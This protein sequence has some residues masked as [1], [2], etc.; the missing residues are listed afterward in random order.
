MKTFSLFCFVFILTSVT[1]PS[2][3]EAQYSEESI[4]IVVHESIETDA[5]NI[6]QLKAFYT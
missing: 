4:S 1:E 2:L 3:L 5:I 6:A